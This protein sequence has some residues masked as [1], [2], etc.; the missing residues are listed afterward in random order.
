[1]RLSGRLNTFVLVLLFTGLLTGC[2]KDYGSDPSYQVGTYV[3][4][5]VIL[6]RHGDRNSGSNY[7]NDKGRA[8][9]QALVGEIG[10]MN[11]IA[12]YCP[13]LFIIRLKGE[14]SP[15]VIKRRYGP[16]I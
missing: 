16:V 11:I 12:I 6:T 8:R 13:D 14:V 7:L 10:D 5:T 9:A 1:M 3:T 2:A 15:V 4:T